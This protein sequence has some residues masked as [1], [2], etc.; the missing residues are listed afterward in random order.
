MSASGTQPIH[1]QWR[2]NGRAIAGAT[3]PVFALDNVSFFD[4]TDYDVIVSNAQAS[5]TSRVAT[6]SVTFQ[7][8]SHVAIH[9]EPTNGV[10]FLG[11][12]ALLRSDSR[13]VQ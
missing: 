2:Q 11:G 6:I 3:G 7:P 8:P 12:S 13:A 1:Y 10:A 9:I 4:A 5:S